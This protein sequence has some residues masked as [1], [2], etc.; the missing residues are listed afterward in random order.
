MALTGRERK[1]MYLAIAAVLLLIVN[2]Y[3]LDPILENRAQAG[4]TCRQMK[5]QVEQAQ[6]TLHRKKLIQR[7]WADMQ[8]SGLGSDIQKAEAMVYRYLDESSA[9]SGLELG[10][11]QPDRLTTETRLGEI[12]FVLSGTGSMRSVT[13]FLWSLETATIPLK[14]K[15]YQLGAKNETAQV[16]T[17]QIE[18]STVYLKDNFEEEKES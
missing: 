11:V 13:Q 5:A 14:I 4:Q 18:L 1:I 12:D 17:V 16:M 3:V 8:Q 10:S 6:T 7:R 2:T 15:S 9:N